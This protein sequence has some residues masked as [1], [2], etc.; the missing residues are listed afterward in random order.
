MKTVCD[1]V[2]ETM[3]IKKFKAKATYGFFSFI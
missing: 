2:S 3:E 1:D